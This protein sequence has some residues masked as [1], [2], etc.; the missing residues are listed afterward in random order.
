MYQL[1]EKIASEC[2][3]K[4]CGDAQNYLA[5]VLK[6]E[7]DD[8][9]EELKKCNVL[10]WKPEHTI[11]K[12]YYSPLDTEK[13]IED[14]KINL[15]KFGILFVDIDVENL[16]LEHAFAIFKIGTELFIVDSYIGLRKCEIRKFSF[17]DFSHILNYKSTDQW[18]QM[19]HCSEEK[20]L[21][22]NQMV[23]ITY[24]Y[25]DTDLKIQ[26]FYRNNIER[27]IK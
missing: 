14:M 19:F 13:I 6:Y 20:K 24:V 1:L 12:E 7:N 3:F 15:E 4:R 17:D 21:C 10:C 9:N 27:I 22:D 18:N 8:F 25:E 5:G 16:E 2:R 11:S 23:W 26:S